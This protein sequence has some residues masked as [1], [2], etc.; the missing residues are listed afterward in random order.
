[1]SDDVAA[2]DLPWTHDEATALRAA[3]LLLAERGAPWVRCTVAL[4]PGRAG[5]WR[6]GLVVEVTD[7]ERGW[8]RA[9]ARV[10]GVTA[11]P[12]QTILALAVRVG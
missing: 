6:R 3:S 7:E 11:R 10:E 5:A 4:P 1:M 9:L 2:L 12:S 8:S